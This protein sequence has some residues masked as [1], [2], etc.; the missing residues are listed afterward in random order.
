MLTL[1]LGQKIVTKVKLALVRLASSLIHNLSVVRI[2]N[3]FAV[4][5]VIVGICMVRKGCKKRQL[6][7]ET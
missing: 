4:L 2:K 5:A 7:P 3:D 6:I 1:L